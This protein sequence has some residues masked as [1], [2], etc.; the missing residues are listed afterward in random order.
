MKDFLDKAPFARLLLALLSGIFLQYYVGF[1]HFS[2][3]FFVLGAVFLIVSYL[4]PQKI[5]YRFR[6]LFGIGTLLVVCGL[7]IVATAQ[8]QSQV[9]FAFQKQPLTYTA[10]IAE[11][12]QIKPRSI[13]CRLSLDDRERHNVVCYFQADSM[14]RTLHVGDRVLFYAELK[15]FKNRGNPDDFDYITY[16]S[17]MGFSGTA[18]IAASRWEKLA[19]GGSS[20]YIYS[21]QLRARILDFYRKLGLCHDN[22]AVFSALTLGY[23]DELDDSVQQT[24]RATGTSHILSVSGLHVAILY[25][26]IASMLSFLP[27][28]RRMVVF[29]Q[30]LIILLLWAYAFLTGLPSS[31]VR[32]TLMI[33]VFCAAVAIRRKAFSYN[34]V[35][36]SAFAMLLY[37]PYD[38]FNIGFQLSFVAV[39]SICFFLP[40]ILKIIQPKNKIIK[41]F[42]ETSAV[43]LAV[44][45]GT[46][47]ICL[48]YFGTFPT[49]FFLTNLVIVPLSTCVMYSSLGIYL[50]AC[51]S[52]L[53]PAYSGGIYFVPVWVLDSFLR[54]LLGF[55]SFFES[56]P[57]ALLKNM[58][59]NLPQMF[60]LMMLSVVAVLFFQRHRPKTL[61]LALVTI[62][63][64][65]LIGLPA[66]AKEKDRSVYVFNRKDKLEIGRVGELCFVPDTTRQRPFALLEISGCKIAV[67]QSD[68][69]SGMKAD[70]PFSVDCLVLTGHDSISM[71]HIKKLFHTKLVVLDGV[72]SARA[73]RR[74][75]RECK[76]LS[77]SSYDVKEKGAFRI[78][79]Y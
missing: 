20:L 68:A 45:L 47:P 16:M 41:F 46:Y 2:I 53:L 37:N 43:S 61:M 51:A 60:L 63:L 74:L 19:P 65:L 64:F 7:G 18:Y 4:L 5:R 3:Y 56:L 10:T 69:W 8:K 48:Y 26:V 70:R 31:V 27:K 25:M 55:A 42:W 13:A 67:V 75:Q 44:Q 24:F 17:R 40:P 79:N 34:T 57:S 12:P 36:F 29:R 52:W 76:K 66:F 9:A 78:K 33:S 32:A 14:S 77:I 73:S 23:M 54:L 6:P 49:Y 72:L 1:A 11:M 58:S 28:N 30:L 15:P 39:L 35:C 21:Q 62:S 71:Y 38:F 50:A 22:F 59:L